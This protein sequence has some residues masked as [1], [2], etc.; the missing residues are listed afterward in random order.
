[1]EAPT[2][3]TVCGCWR[4]EKARY[5]PFLGI[6]AIG[7]DAQLAIAAQGPQPVRLHLLALAPPAPPACTRASSAWC[8]HSLL[9]LVP[10]PAQRQ[11][12]AYMHKAMAGVH[13]VAVQHTLS[14]RTAGRARSRSRGPRAR[15]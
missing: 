5:A 4:A 1:M 8:L 9:T 3:L 14:L 10:L 13:M 12:C 6:Q 2:R 11:S 15:R 7:P